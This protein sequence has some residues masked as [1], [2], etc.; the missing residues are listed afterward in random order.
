MYM[1]LGHPGKGANLRR[2]ENCKGETRRQGRMWADW[3]VVHWYAGHIGRIQLIQRGK[4]HQHC[5]T[6]AQ[7]NAKDP[8]FSPSL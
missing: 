8:G 2:E 1:F 5:Y 7:K 4:R 6:V 3:R